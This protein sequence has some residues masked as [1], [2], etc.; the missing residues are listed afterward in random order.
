MKRMVLIMAGLAT[1][2]AVPVT[3]AD[4]GDKLRELMGDKEK[5]A[6]SAPAAL[7]PEQT[8]KGVLEALSVGVKR[9]VDGLGQAGGY[10]DNPQVRIP[11]PEQLRSVE[12]LVR[13]M[14]QDKYA[15]QF[16]ATMNHA[17]EEAVPVATDIF[18]KSIREMEVAD[19]KAIVKGPEDAATRYF[20]N[21]T[22]DSLHEAFLPI[23]KKATEQANVTAAYKQLVER[24]GPFASGLAKAESLDLDQHVTNK[25]L[26]G[27]FVML[28][29]EEK[30]IRED[31]VARTTEL[32]KKVFGK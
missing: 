27:L 18:L 3:Q 22:R 2:L 29:K 5:G 19:A 6:S 21:H 24:A 10:L 13:R 17:A 20:E 14:G 4:L 15:D 11:M 28:A 26:D 7:S 23:V 12:K 25:A 8:T 31:P 9:A 32:L 1:A 16:V 30:R